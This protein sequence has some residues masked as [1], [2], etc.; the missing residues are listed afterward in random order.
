M[1]KWPG[2]FFFLFCR[3]SK[4]N[5]SKENFGTVGRKELRNGILPHLQITASA[6]S[7]LAI[8]WG[9]EAPSDNLMTVK[10]GK[11]RW[12]VCMNL[13]GTLSPHL[14][15]YLYSIG[16]EFLAKSDLSFLV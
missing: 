3:N 13:G 16:T 5:V 2:T 14:E 15:T 12:N 6:L 10:G 1:Y 9:T 11:K 7:F 8:L 4:I